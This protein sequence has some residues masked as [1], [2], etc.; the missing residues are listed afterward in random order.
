[1]EYLLSLPRWQFYI[2]SLLLD[3][4]KNLP[5][6]RHSPNFL[7]SPTQSLSPFAVASMPL[8]STMMPYV[9]SSV[10]VKIVHPVP[11]M[12]YIDEEGKAVEIW[13]HGVFNGRRR[14]VYLD[15]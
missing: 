13:Y 14:G 2:S 12:T 7:L 11:P 5:Y 6:I 1:M 15:W 8:Q 10:M 4:H 3:L 9:D